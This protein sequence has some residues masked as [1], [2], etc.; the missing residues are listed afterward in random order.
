MMAE[1]GREAR[2]TLPTR[3]NVLNERSLPVLKRQPASSTAEEEDLQHMK[4]TLLMK[5][6]A[7]QQVRDCF[8]QIQSVC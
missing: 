3:R 5:K 8:W 6:G 2:K 7:K 4:F 1:S